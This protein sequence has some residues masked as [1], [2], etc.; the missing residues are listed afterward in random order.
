MVQNCI[1][2]NVLDPYKNYLETLLQFE[3]RLSHAVSARYTQGSY[4]TTA[5]A[6]SLTPAYSLGSIVTDFPEAHPHHHSAPP[7]FCRT[8]PID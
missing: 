7:Y 4:F 1:A 6:N 3:N 8:V 2:Q 5:L